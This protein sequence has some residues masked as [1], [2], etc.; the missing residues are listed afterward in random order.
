MNHFCYL[1]F[2]FFILACLFLATLWPH[3]GKGLTSCVFDTFPYGV[4]GQVYH[5]IL[6][7]PDL[8][9]LSYF[10]KSLIP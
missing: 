9:H 3:T 10:Y 8:C 2:V 1:C 4:L 6:L 5:L 7:N